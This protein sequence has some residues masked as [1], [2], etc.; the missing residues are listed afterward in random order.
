MVPKNL[1][2]IYLGEYGDESEY[3]FYLAEKWEIAEPDW[4]HRVYV[5]EEVDEIVKA[6]SDRA[7]EA[8]L[9]I[10]GLSYRCDLA[11]LILVY[12]MGG[13]YL[14]L[15]TRPNPNVQLYDYF[16]VNE[17]TKAGFC[18]EFLFDQTDAEGKPHDFKYV[19]MNHIFV[20]EKGSP[21][22]KSMIDSMV[23]EILEERSDGM[24]PIYPNIVSTMAWANHIKKEL[25]SVLGRDYRE[26]HFEKGYG[27]VGTF[28]IRHD[29]ANVKIKKFR[30]GIAHVGSIILKDFLDTNA[31]QNSL[32][33]IANLYKDLNLHN[34]EIKINVRGGADGLSAKRN[35]S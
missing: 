19:S 31:N 7:Y 9:R 35:K 5:N 22:I 30:S 12:E 11:R 21:L 32:A 28:W 10:P 29:G 18:F 23:E 25:D 14:D 16:V 27:P 15:D 20:A 13:M 3:L 34:G 1:I 17:Q 2:Q 33:E 4:N 6:Y 8:Y 26:Y 24:T